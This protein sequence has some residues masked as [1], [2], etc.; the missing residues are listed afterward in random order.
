MVANNLF[1]NNSLSGMNIFREPTHANT[2]ANNI[3]I[4]NVVD[5]T[6]DDMGGKCYHPRPAWPECG[7]FNNT[8]NK[9][10]YTRPPS[11]CSETTGG[12]CNHEAGTG[13]CN[14][15]RSAPLE[16]PLKSASATVRLNI[17]CVCSYSIRIDPYLALFQIYSLPNNCNA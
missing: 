9:N 6:I 3:A 1:A 12:K 13:C 15:G 16:F 11:P 2:F 5:A 17:L 8:A 7:P 4:D 10:V 14:P